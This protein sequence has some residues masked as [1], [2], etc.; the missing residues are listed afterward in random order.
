MLGQVGQVNVNKRKKHVT[1]IQKISS[2]QGYLVS[3]GWMTC[4]RYVGVEMMEFRCGTAQR[5]SHSIKN[6]KTHEPMG[7]GLSFVVQIIQRIKCDY[8]SSWF[9]FVCRYSREKLYYLL[10]FEAKYIKTAKRVQKIE[11]AH[12]TVYEGNLVQIVKGKRIKGTCIMVCDGLSRGFLGRCAEVRRKFEVD[13][14]LSLICF[15]LRFSC[16]R[17]YLTQVTL[18]CVFTR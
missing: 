3:Y 10:R 16:W 2:L 13:E 4:T 7:K 6:Q 15:L 17:I 9:Q 5:I 1:F 14:T 11:A 18:I 8:S 12:D